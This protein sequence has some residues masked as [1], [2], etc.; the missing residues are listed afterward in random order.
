MDENIFVSFIIPTY[1]SGNYIGRCL[2]AIK[3][4]DHPQDRF[5]IVI[6]DNGSSDDTLEIAR[7]FTDKIVINT[8]SLVSKLRN[9]GAAQA[10]GDLLI[11]I[12]S[13]CVIHRNWIKKR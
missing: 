10:I 13:D 2:E 9:L 3:T 1:N 8:T 11:F 6:V 12:D 5:E 4:I 7:R